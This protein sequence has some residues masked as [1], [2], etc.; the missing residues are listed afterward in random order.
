MDERAHDGGHV[1]RRRRKICTE[2]AARLAQLD[3]ACADVAD[4]ELPADEVVQA[5]PARDDVTARCVQW[6][7]RAVQRVEAF[8]LL[9]LDQRE[10]ES[11]LAGTLGVVPVADDAGPGDQLGAVHGTLWLS[12]FRT[13]VD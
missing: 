4:H 3:A 5:H 13:H 11:W 12:E 9:R 8:D 10:I 6:R 7:T 2:D 1:D